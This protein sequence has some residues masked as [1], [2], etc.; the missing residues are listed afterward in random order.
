MDM[1]KSVSAWVDAHEKE[2]IADVSRLVA[3]KSVRG[4]AVEGMP[5]GEGP[6]KALGE[7]LKI[8]AEHGFAVHNYNNYA[9]AA[10]LCDKDTALDILGHLDVVGEGDGWNTDPYTAVQRDGF[11]Y[12]RGTDDDKGPVIAALYAMRAV[13]ELGLPMKYNTRLIMGTDEES[14]SSDLSYY[15]SVEKPAPN[16]FSPDSSFPVYNVEKG[17][18]KP[19]FK[20]T[21]AAEDALPRVT[22]FDGGYRINV[23]PADA[24]ARVAG[25]TADELRGICA[26]V[27][28]ECGVKL[29]VIE[30]ENGGEISVS[31]AAAHASKPEEGINGLTALI[32]ILTTLPLADCP[33]TLAL[34]Q[35]G[36]VFPHGDGGGKPAGI[37]MEDE[38]SGKLT[39]AFSL[40]SMDAHGISGQFD[41]RVPICATEENCAGIVEKRLSDLGFTVKGEMLPPHHT[42]ADSEFIKILLKCYEQY[43]G[44]PGE[45]KSMGGGTYVHDVEG[46]VAF[47]A[48]MPGFRSN[49]H[50]ANERLCIRDILTACKI[51]A[52]VIADMCCE[53]TGQNHV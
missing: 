19:I 40:L 4:D 32:K 36:E 53:T 29:T 41:S 10:D 11:L 51:F 49:L 50:S 17:S 27:A 14:G 6:A 21:W 38:I 42:P 44:L 28:E 30:F 25:I 20:K 43:T 48:G 13:Q 23:L 33:S 47:G 46:G 52:Q 18:Y 7:A 2:L 45:C 5:F 16:T 26:P 15:Y 34:K 1:Q 24:K 35:L 39:L 37:A 22:F 8:C 9:G 31:G 3:I 12:G